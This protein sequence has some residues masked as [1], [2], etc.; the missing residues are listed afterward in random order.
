MPTDKKS[1]DAYNAYAKNW[2]KAKRDGSAIYHI[3]LEKP[4]MYSKLPDLK[5]KTILCIGCGSGEE[6][7]YL[8]AHGAKKVVGIDISEGLIAIAKETYPNFEFHVM[9][10]EDLTFPKDSFDVAFSS[11]TMHYLDDWTKVLTSLHKVLKKGGIYL[12]STNHPFFSATEKSEDEK[13][14]TRLL[15]YR[16]V[17]NT[18]ELRIYGNYFE[19]NK[20]E[21]L[22]NN[23]LTATN[24]HRPF[25]LIIKD[26]VGSGFELLDIVEPKALFESK[27]QYKKF[28]EIHQKLPEFIV[29]E[30]RSK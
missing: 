5:D 13:V 23:T 29:Y 19:P 1:I 22:L 20:Y 10:M 24:Y 26:I 7:E 17:K 15:G 4:A 8:Y 14:K 18:D 16:D 28:W 6:V 12:F 21:L 27:E 3:Y 11:L 9:D 2:A 25:S 30:L